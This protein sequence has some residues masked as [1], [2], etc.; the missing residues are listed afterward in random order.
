MNDGWRFLGLVLE[1]LS[2]LA[3]IWL[4]IELYDCLYAYFVAPHQVL[5]L[6][7]GRVE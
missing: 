2:A 5:S 6:A 4:L 1:F 3:A 7:F